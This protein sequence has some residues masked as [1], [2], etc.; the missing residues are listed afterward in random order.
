MRERAFHVFRGCR[1][2]YDGWH[3][4]EFSESYDFWRSLK[5]LLGCLLNVQTVG[6]L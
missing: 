1:N 6:T 3:A 2:V 4:L 5:V